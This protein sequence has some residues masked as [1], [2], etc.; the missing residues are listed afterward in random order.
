M[1]KKLCK[2]ISTILCLSLI[3]GLTACAKADT[4]NG[5]TECLGELTMVLDFTNLYEYVG[6]VDH[7]FVGTVEEAEYYIPEKR[8]EYEQSFSQYQIHV[9]E[10]LK[11]ELIDTITC[12]KMGGLKKDGTMLLIAAETP[13]GNLIMD[14]GLPEVGKQYIFLAYSQQDGSLTLSEILDNREYSEDLLAE[15]MDYVDNE[16]PYERERFVTIYSKEEKK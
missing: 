3:F 6:I 15:Y 4:W 12:S 7:V 10:N 13:N 16:I 11:G 2:A 9:D 1:K 5:E 8:T 14:N